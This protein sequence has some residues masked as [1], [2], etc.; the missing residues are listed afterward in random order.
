[1]KGNKEIV[2]RECHDPLVFDMC[3]D[4][5]A[6]TDPWVTL[7]MDKARCRM[8]FEGLGKEVHLA[9]E[10]ES[11]AGFMILQT[12]GS[13][14]GYIQTLCAAPRFRGSGVGTQLLQYA[15]D[16]VSAYSPNL[17]IC[18]SEFNKGA[19]KLYLNFGF[20]Q[21]GVIP[22]FVKEGYTELLLRKTR[23]PLVKG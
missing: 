14:R 2:I 6:A 21:V 9:W 13:F 19:L 12:A 18:V 17:F 3:A 16:R 8:G 15:E 11:I 1:M 10:G 22:D 7:G 23:G 20:K 5:M 4:L